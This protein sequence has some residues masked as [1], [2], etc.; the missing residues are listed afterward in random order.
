[1][2]YCHAKRENTRL[3]DGFTAVCSFNEKLKEQV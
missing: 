1:M 3:K 2:D